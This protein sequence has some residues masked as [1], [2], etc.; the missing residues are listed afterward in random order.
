MLSLASC[1]GKSSNLLVR[2]Q[3]SP[4]KVALIYTSELFHAKFKSAAE[5]VDPAKRYL[6]P[7]F[8]DDLRTS[9][10]DSHHLKVGSVTMSD[11]NAV[12]ILLGTLCSTGN[13][14]SLKSLPK[15]KYCVQ[16]TN[17]HSSNLAF[18]IDVLKIPG[19]GWFVNI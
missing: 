18:K 5:L 13:M 14:R 8:T 9:S 4:G 3:M 16:N 2:A 12:V 19:K 15:G 11:L 1:G 6:V 10:V 7:V 17:P